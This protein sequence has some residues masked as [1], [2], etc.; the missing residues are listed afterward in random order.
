MKTIAEWAEDLGTVEVLSKVGVDYVQG[1]AIA[2]PQH[3][4]KILG[5]ESSASF[6]QDENVAR[7]VRH[8]LAAAQTM[9]LW[10]QVGGP[11]TPS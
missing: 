8:S 6:I 4:D 7:F 9:E 10:E 2:R 3:P 5:A 1:Y 11:T